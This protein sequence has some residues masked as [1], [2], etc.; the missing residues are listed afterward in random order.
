VKERWLTP[1]LEKYNTL[2]DRDRGMLTALVVF[3][4]AVLIYLL[5]WTPID[6]YRQRGMQDRNRNLELLEMMRRTET[7]A[8]QNRT[9]KQ[10]ST[11]GKSLLSI[12]SREAQ[13]LNIKA[14][15]LQ[16]EGQNAVSLW[17]DNIAFNDL[18]ELLE[19]VQSEHGVSVQQIVIDRGESGGSVR[20]RLVLKA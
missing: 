9:S 8:R 3:L 17:F 2:P 14:N 16:P 18:L 6:E 5:I 10:P 7:Q 20:A 1:L 11:T 4:V 19:K 13:R 12:I 15:R